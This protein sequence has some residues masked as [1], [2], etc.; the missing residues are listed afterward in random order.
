MT[1]YHSY[2][3]DY[4]GGLSAAT[5]KDATVD[6]HPVKFVCRYLSGFS[7]DLTPSEAKSLSAA[8]LEIVVVWE[9]TATRAEAGSSAGTS[10]ARAALAEA[11]RCGMPAGRPIYFAVDE[12]TT[13]GPNVT[14]Y[15]QGVNHV[16]GAAR[17]GVYGSY[18]VVKALR[19]ANLV[20]WSWQ[21]YAWSA[22]QWDLDAQLQQYSNNH[23]LGGHEV[24]YDRSTVPDFG[25]WAVGSIPAPSQEV[26]MLSGS[27]TGGKGE[28]PPVVTKGG[29]FTKI[30]LAWDNSYTDA[31][32]PREAQAVIRLA[33]HVGGR[34]GETFDVTVGATLADAK[35]RPDGVEH[36]LPAGCDYVAVVRK[37]D[38]TRPVGFSVY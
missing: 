26:D 3:I 8:G 21:T 32:T 14:A 13:V 9:T 31:N 35:G 6:G 15:F 37:D 12:D 5:L 4:T 33:P 17:S 19:A 34:K 16:L 22:G 10:D 11:E 2:G 1:T 27:F 20:H 29:K 23:M 18:R 30:F 7:K 36:E 24:D 25:Q 28:K 38:G